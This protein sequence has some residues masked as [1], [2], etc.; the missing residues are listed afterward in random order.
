LKQ[1]EEA[2][3]L[4]AMSPDK[5]EAEPTAQR[6]KPSAI[7]GWFIVSALAAG[8][9]V[10]AWIFERRA[11]D[12]ECEAVLQDYISGRESPDPA[13]RKLGPGVDIGGFYRIVI[14]E[15]K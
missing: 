14:A 4:H 5:N 8:F 13:L 11:L 1:P 12:A 15:A 2:F 7:N 6:R 9:A 10:G 3:T